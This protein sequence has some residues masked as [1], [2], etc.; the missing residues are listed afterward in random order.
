M[1]NQSTDYECNV[2]QRHEGPNPWRPHKAVACVEGSWGFDIYR[3]MSG[4]DILGEMPVRAGDV[5]VSRLFIS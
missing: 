2:M 3:L 5:S 1:A 4:K